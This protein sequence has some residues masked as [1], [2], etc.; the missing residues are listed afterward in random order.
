MEACIFL[1]F[2]KAQQL[3]AKKKSIRHEKYKIRFDFDDLRI[4]FAIIC[5]LTTYI[6]HTL[7]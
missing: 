1:G 2:T 6:S 5:V 7:L 3:G 4:R